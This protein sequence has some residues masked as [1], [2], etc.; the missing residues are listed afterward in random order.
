MR[1]D[2]A[3]RRFPAS[4]TQRCL[5]ASGAVLVFVLGLL[6]ASPELHHWLHREAGAAGHE[7][8]VTLFLHG[9]ETAAPPLVTVAAPPVRLATVAAPIGAPVAVAPRYRLLPGRA[10]PVG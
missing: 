4:W 7:C 5:A 8:A 1:G 2:A 3:H 6:A 10:P 9:V